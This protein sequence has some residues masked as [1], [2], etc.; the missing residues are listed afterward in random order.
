MH[1]SHRYKCWHQNQY[2][3]PVITLW[4]EQS[5]SNND[6]QCQHIPQKTSLSNRYGFSGLCF[7]FFFFFHC[8]ACKENMYLH[9]H[10]IKKQQRI[11]KLGLAWFSLPIFKILAIHLA[12]LHSRTGEISTLLVETVYWHLQTKALF[13]K[14]P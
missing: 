8:W 12:R 3:H 2:H 6:Q 4:L 10:W 5:L 1:T 9:K 7:V 14:T 13:H 11:Y